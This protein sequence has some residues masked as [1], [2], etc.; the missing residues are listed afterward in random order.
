MF[1]SV[2]EA[3]CVDL[4]GIYFYKHVVTISRLKQEQNATFFESQQIEVAWG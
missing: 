1:D 3:K 2:V 4:L